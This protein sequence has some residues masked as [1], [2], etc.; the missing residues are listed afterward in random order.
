MEGYLILVLGVMVQTRKFQ[1]LRKKLNENVMNVLKK[2]L[3]SFAQQ[4][5][6]CFKKCGWLHGF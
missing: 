4:G 6:A 1:V 3:V 5:S 2:L